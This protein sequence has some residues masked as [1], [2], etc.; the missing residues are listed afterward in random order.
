MA[1]EVL[2][3]W[4]WGESQ[5]R[6]CVFGGN[7]MYLY[8]L[9]QIRYLSVE[10][11]LSCKT[12]PLLWL[13]TEEAFNDWHFNTDT[14]TENSP[15]WHFKTILNWY[16]IIYKYNINVITHV[17]FTDNS[18]LTL[19]L[20][21]LRIV[22]STHQSFSHHQKGRIDSNTVNPSLSTGKDFLIHSL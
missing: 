20:A 7:K 18:T 19:I 10:R 14:D 1:I 9:K 4:C 16:N 13:T 21:T 3:G 6:A 15:R 11:S 22:V 17:C 2:H 5:V 8:N 12:E